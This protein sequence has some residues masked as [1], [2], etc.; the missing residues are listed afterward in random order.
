MEFCKDCG[1]V[2]HLF[3]KN[4]SGLCSS[5]IQHAKPSVT[6]VAPEPEAPPAAETDILLD[7]VISSS[8][9]KITIHSKEGWQLWSGPADKETPMAEI[10]KSAR[11][12]YTIRNRRKAKK[13]A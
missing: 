13:T 3:G 8:E 1:A 5:C 9:G 4:S 11:L 7:A 2:L 10:L 12:I 6:I